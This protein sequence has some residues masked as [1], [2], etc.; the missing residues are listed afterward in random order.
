MKKFLIIRFS[1]IGDIV[2][3][4]PVIRYL[5]TQISNSEVHFLTKKS[6]FPVLENN[7]YVDKFHLFDKNLFEIIKILKK[8]NFDYI[9]DLHNNLRSTI[10]KKFLK[11]KSFSFEKLNLKKYL[12]VNFKINKMPN[13]HIVDR[14]VKTL[15][16][17]DIQIDKKGLDYFIGKKN[18]VNLS[19]YFD[20]FP[21]KYIAFV[22]G[23]KHKTKQL[24][25]EKIISI[26]EKIDFPI[27]LIGG[28][29]EKEKSKKIIS[30]IRNN[31]I[32]N[33][34][35]D[36]NI[37]QSASIIEKS[38]LV[39]THDTGL[40]HIAAAF[41]KKIISIWGNTVIDFG[42]YPYLPDKNS[43]IIEVKNLKCRP[44]S[45]I[46]FKECPKKHFFCIKKI[47][48]NQIANF[49]KKII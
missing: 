40:M 43:K 10:L 34:C 49:A 39:I 48:E 46:G 16:K 42:M 44:C 47:D 7:I 31:E 6:F 25:T 20:N 14:Y 37:N 26:C 21:K 18:E 4:T 19:D 15:Q 5:K 41:H 36:F 33:T 8:E 12:L 29:E 38:A 30:S 2:L 3:T 1:S 13:L 9:I 17:F 22:I 27:V 35:G 23:A 32:F 45:K 28:K 24:T 11:K